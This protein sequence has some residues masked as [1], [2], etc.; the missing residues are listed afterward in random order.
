LTEEQSAQGLRTAVS[1]DIAGW[2]WSI[3]VKPVPSHFTYNGTTIALGAWAIVLL[4]LSGLMQYITRAQT[5]ERS[6]RER[7][8]ELS[9][10]NAALESEITERTRVEQELRTAKEQAE[11]ANRAKSE[12]LAMMSHELRTPLNAIIGFSEILSEQ[13][14]GPIGNNQYRGYATDIR[15]SGTHLLSLINDI[16]DLSK[17]EANRFELHEEN[18]DLVEAL[19]SIFP[20]IQ[21]RMDATKLE[22]KADLPNPMYG[23]RADRRAIRQMLI[24]L[25]SNSIK[26]TPEG[27]SITFQVAIRE[28]GSFVV[29]V[30]DTGIGIAEENLQTVLLPFDQVDSSLARKYEGTGLGLPL[31]KRLAELHGGHLE[32]ESRLGV[33]TTVS[34]VFPKERIL[35]ASDRWG[36]KVTPLLAAPAKPSDKVARRMARE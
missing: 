4:F 18:V 34:L 7:T 12:F 14:L 16:L 30:R 31:T 2:H 1:H 11:V 25:L 23:L 32:I 22:F 10:A 15:S 3:M 21:E 28:D 19:H 5:I 9:A 6:V 29:T 27:G 20:I 26:F 35:E 8:A 17:V 36:S 24:N 33:G 13:T